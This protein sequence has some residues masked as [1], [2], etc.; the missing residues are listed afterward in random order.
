MTDPIYLVYGLAFFSLGLAAWLEIRESSGLAL[1]RQLPWLAAFGITHAAVEWCSLFMHGTPNNI[2]VAMPTLRLALLQISAV[3]LIRFGI[4]LIAEV[5]P[6]PDWVTFARAVLFVP[7][8][9]IVAYALVTV[10]TDSRAN[11][12]AEIWSRY[13]LLLP[14]AL[15][16]MVGFARHWHR[17]PFTALRRTY[18]W[19]LVAAIGSLFFAITAGLIVPDGPYGL[20]HHINDAT[21]KDLTHV[22]LSLWRTGVAV[23]LAISVIRALGVFAAERKSEIVQL[24]RE[25]ERAQHAS[26]AAQSEARRVAEN[27]IEAL[28]QISRQIATLEPLDTV[29]ASIVERA[30]VLLGAK[31]V[32]LALW[33]E[34]YS[35]LIVKA[36][37]SPTGVSAPDARISQGPIA[38]AARQHKPTLLLDGSNWHCPLLKSMLHSAVVAPLLFEG[39]TLGV[40]WAASRDDTSFAPADV[41]RVEHLSA[42]AVIAI[43]HALMAGRLQSLAVVE[44]RSRIAREMHDGL[45]QLLGY[46]SLE[47]QTLEALVRQENRDS[48]LGELA[49]VR[50]Q[51]NSAQAD[52]RENILSLRTTLAGDAGLLQ[53][54]EEYVAEFGIQTGI[55][56]HFA[57]ELTDAPRLSSLAETQLVCIVQEALANVRKHACARQ[58]QLR[59]LA[60]NGCLQVT[61]TDDGVGFVPR[62]ARRHFGLQTMRERSQSV[63]GG[64]TVTSKPD[65][66]TQVAVW[67]PRLKQ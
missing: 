26:L 21:V 5:G 25:R 4:G 19:L 45:A 52:V 36:F 12:S 8:T 65:E 32:V 59:L 43:Q 49:Q 61:V 10:T 58:V 18:N 2:A 17:V 33:D 40:L 42:Q 30:R 7:I 23:L 20:A 34:Q 51:I 48:A 6:L 62:T 15:L 46:M 16:T 53:S 56:T 41:D 27:W 55:E 38:E 11:L 39:E 64:L 60:R 50:T 47:M 57:N 67:L 28:V 66:G 31:A 3:L 63:G 22:P 29:L 54:L 9:L 13:L 24:Q 14:G 37:A 44:E 1:G 35:D